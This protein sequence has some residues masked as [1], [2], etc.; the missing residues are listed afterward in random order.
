[1]GWLEIAVLCL[2]VMLV[3]VLVSEGRSDRCTTELLGQ[4]LQELRLQHERLH[5]LSS[6][7]YRT[8][9]LYVDVLRELRDAEDNQD[10][11]ELPQPPSVPAPGQS[12]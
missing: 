3:F 1:M 8:E 5:L 10:T 2:Q 4:V 12:S 7:V 11:P 6:S 9:R